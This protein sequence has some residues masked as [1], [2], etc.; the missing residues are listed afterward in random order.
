LAFLACNRAI[1][2]GFRDIGR[3]FEVGFG[4]GFS[5]V[6]LFFWKFAFSGGFITGFALLVRAMDHR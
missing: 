5:G 4:R 1:I 3:R 2:L 6:D